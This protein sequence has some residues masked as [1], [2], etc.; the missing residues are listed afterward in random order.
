MLTYLLLSVFPACLLIAG[1]NDLLEMKIPNWISLLLI[2][3]FFL[4]VLY[5]GPPLEDVFANIALS[6]GVFVAGFSLFAINKLGGGDVKIL[7]AAS[8]W[9]GVGAFLSFFVKMILIG[10]LFAFLILMF[11]RTPLLPVYAHTPWVMNLHQSAKQMPYGVAIAG[12]GIFSLPE[13]YFFAMY[14]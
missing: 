8:L 3:V 9:I 14:S 2:S 10:G 13:T 11:R 5:L 4:S 1:G 12:V 6:I 7:A